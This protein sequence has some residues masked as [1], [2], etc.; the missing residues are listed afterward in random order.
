MVEKIDEGVGMMLAELTRQGVL[1]NTLFVVSSDN[2]GA[3]WSD[4]SPLF[5]HKSTLWEGGI[6]VPCIMRWP[7]QLPRR[8]VISQ[9]AITMDLTA[10][11]AAI[12]GAQPAEGQPFDGINLLPILTGKQSAMERTF[13]WR[14]NRTGRQQKAVRHGNW[15]YL[16]DGNVELLFDLSK[17]IGERRNLA[18]HRQDIFTDL[19]RR[20]AL[21]EEEMAK[22]QPEFLVK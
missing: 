16:E 3:L 4:N 18:M 1:D 21:W 17:D 14:I 20:L 7:A 19:K 8:K 5:H 22:H 13:Y 11:F 9:P 12:A 10:T 15:K 2:G 6:R